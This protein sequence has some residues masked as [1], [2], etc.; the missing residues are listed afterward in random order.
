M[1]GLIEYS[2][3]N[4]T[5]ATLVASATLLTLTGQSGGSTETGVALMGADLVQS[6]VNYVRF[7]ATP[8]LSRGATDTMNV[9]ASVA[10][11]GGITRQ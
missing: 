6:N 1:A 9:G 7:K 3:D 4:S 2:A 11:F 8:N 10:I 5:W